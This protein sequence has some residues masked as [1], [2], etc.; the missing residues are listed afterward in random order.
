MFSHSFGSGDKPKPKVPKPSLKL[1]E[2]PSQIG[3]K[4]KEYAG[5]VWAGFKRV[6]PDLMQK[7]KELREE[8]PVEAEPHI[9][10]LSDFSNLPDLS[11]FFKVEGVD[12][13]DEKER[14]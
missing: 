3:K 9:P 8:P 6:G 4:L 7:I 5:L 11:D 14:S 1:P 2:V 10:D 13:E 12:E